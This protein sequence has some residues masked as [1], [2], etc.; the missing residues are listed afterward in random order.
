MTARKKKTNPPIKPDP[1]I[2]KYARSI[3]ALIKANIALTAENV[4]L[5]AELAKRDAKDAAQ[6]M[7]LKTAA[8]DAGVP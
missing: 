3:N 5:Q 7:P 1:P 4:K 2:R 6:W 8:L